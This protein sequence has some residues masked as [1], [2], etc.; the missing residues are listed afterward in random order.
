MKEKYLDIIDD[1]YSLIV[2]CAF[3]FSKINYLNSKHGQPER[4]RRISVSILDW[5]FFHLYSHYQIFFHS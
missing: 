2:F 5:Q 4:I 1:K 3:S